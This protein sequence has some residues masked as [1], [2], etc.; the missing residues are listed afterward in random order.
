MFYTQPLE[1]ATRKYIDKILENLGWSVDEFD[2]KCNVFTERVRT[3]EERSKILQKYPKGKFPDYVLYS[4]NVP[5]AIIEAKRPGSNL[6]EALKQGKLYADCINV[7]IVFA[8]DGSIIESIWS[9]SKESLYIDDEILTNLVSEKI[10]KRFKENGSKIQLS[11][12]NTKTREELLKVFGK[13]ND[14]L[15]NEGMREGIERFTEFSNLLFLK[16]IDEIEDQRESD[17]EERRIGKQ[18]TWSSFKDKE[19][20]EMIDYINDT[21]LP[22]LV[23][24][25]NHSGEVFSKELQ[26]KNPI[27]IKKI[28]NE[29]SNLTLLD[30]DSDVKGDAFEYFLKNSVSIGNDL[31]EYYTPRHIV[32]L[33]V[34][35]VNPKFGDKVYDPCCGTGGFLIQAFKHIKEH[36]NLTPENRK[37]LEE[38]TIFGGE[39]TG[40]AKLAKMNMILAGDGHTHISQGDSLENK[41]SNEFDCVLSNFPFRQTT[42]F[43]HLYGMEGKSADITF[44]KHI[45]ESLK[46]GGIAGV[47]V[48]DSVLFATDKAS[49]NMRKILIEQCEVIT[50]I[51]LDPFTFVPYTKQPTSIIIFKKGGSTKNIWFADIQN[52]GFTKSTKRKATKENDIPLVRHFWSEKSE[53]DV[54]FNASIDKLDTATYKLFLNYYK[55]QNTFKKETSVKLSKIVEKFVLGGTPSRKVKEFYGDEHIWLSISDMGKKFLTESR[56]KLSNSGSLKLGVNRLVPK[57]QVL[58]SFKLTLGKTGITTRALYTNEAIAWFK[59]KKE[60]DTHEVKEYL[61]HVL[62]HIDFRPFAQ[63]AAKGLTLNSKILPNVLIPFDLNEENRKSLVKKIESIEKSIDIKAKELDA[64]KQKYSEV[65]SNIFS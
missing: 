47:V 11:Q 6:S 43:A 46:V 59:L 29:L 1:S 44:M 35:L 38:E 23:G 12:K 33:L 51:Q 62:P 10:L 50:I 21:I 39:L 60:Y 37:K 32:K 34:D 64:E 36:T 48:P 40:T 61:Y 31:G 25:Y 49:I 9:E 56:E 3:T 19:G 53:S 13:A 20:Q 57:D 41:R 22:K 30:I 27:N 45:Y 17:G 14:L 42:E 52:D 58:M 15:R 28:V 7:P 65:M 54:S 5:I 24:K 16:L 4:N 8:I 2:V 63:R 26:I 18:Y 55:Y